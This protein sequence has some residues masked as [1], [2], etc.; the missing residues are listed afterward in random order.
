MNKGRYIAYQLDG[1]PGTSK[2]IWH[3]QLWARFELDTNNYDTGWKSDNYD[4]KMTNSMA[5]YIIG[6]KL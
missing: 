5:E 2:C 4:E 1:H 3:R 6:S